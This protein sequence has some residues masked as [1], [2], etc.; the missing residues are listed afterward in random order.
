MP[1]GGG[2]VH[3]FG[4]Y[5]YLFFLQSHVGSLS[6]FSIQEFLLFRLQMEM[7]RAMEVLMRLKPYEKRVVLIVGQEPDGERQGYGKKS[8]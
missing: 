6:S 5:I 8:Q 1:N 7:E 2:D 4:P 3:G